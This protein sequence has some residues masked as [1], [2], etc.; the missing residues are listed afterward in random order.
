MVS[1][2]VAGSTKGGGAATQPRMANP[3]PPDGAAGRWLADVHRALAAAAP[4]LLVVAHDPDPRGGGV[5]WL[6]E[7]HAPD[8]AA[9]PAFA[10][11]AARWDAVPAPVRLLLEMPVW[12]PPGVDARALARRR[13]AWPP[14]GA[15]RWAHPGG[16]PSTLSTLHGLAVAGPPVGGAGPSTRLA[17]Q[18]VDVRPVAFKA[19]L[20]AGRPPRARLAAWLEG[21]ARAVP[22]PP[23]TAAR[24]PT[25]ARRGA[26][27]AHVDAVRA[28]CVAAAA[29][30]RATGDPDAPVDAAGRA[31]AWRLGARCVDAEILVA[32]A[33]AP[34]PHVVVYAGANHVRA[35]RAWRAAY[36]GAVGPAAD[37]ARTGIQ[38]VQ[39]CSV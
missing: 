20:L 3:A 33:T 11:A 22:P 15:P 36:G 23:A 9:S 10:A 26:L 35:V 19:A 27:G 4:N 13:A 17:V 12:L 28:A 38:T 18:P 34:E 24:D 6:G 29:A 16:A 31:R 5:H 32:L 7:R 39:T 37:P 2:A 21:L 1:A 30:L 14:G 8:G 25:G